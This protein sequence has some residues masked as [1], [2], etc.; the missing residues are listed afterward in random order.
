MPSLY[1]A[2]LPDFLQ[3]LHLSNITIWH[4]AVENRVETGTVV[5]FQQMGHFVQH[6]VFQN[7][8]APLGQFQGQ[9][10]T[11]CGGGATAPAALHPA[12]AETSDLHTL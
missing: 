11:A 1:E 2:I 10:D 7:L 8:P 9:A 4:V 3:P 12:D 6:H 5:G